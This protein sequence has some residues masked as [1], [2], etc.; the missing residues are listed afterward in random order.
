MQLTDGILGSEH[1]IR[2]DMLARHDFLTGVLPKVLASSL[3]SA[4]QNAAIEDISLAIKG[5][6]LALLNDGGI[7]WIG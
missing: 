6:P 2:D 7:A 1:T 4:I 5:S 3:T